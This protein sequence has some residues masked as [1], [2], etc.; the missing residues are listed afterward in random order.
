MAAGTI[1]SDFGAQ[2]MK[3]WHC[4]YF[5][6]FYLPWSDETGCYDLSFFNTEF[7]ASFFTKNNYI[8]KN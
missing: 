1:H 6:P 8:P 3:I 4:L 5:F 2:E 7:Q